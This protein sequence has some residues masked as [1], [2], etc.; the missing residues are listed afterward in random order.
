MN[1]KDNS[2]KQVL[3]I[4][5]ERSIRESIADYLEDIGCRPYQASDGASAIRMI[6]SSSFDAIVVDLTMPGIDGY[7]VVKYVASTKPEVPVIVLSG[8]G[9][10]DRAMESIRYGAWDYISKP[11]SRMEVLGMAL[12]RGFEKAGLLKENRMYKEHLEEEVEKK[13]AQILSLSNEMIRTQ[14]EIILTLGDVVE[15]RSHETAH[16]VDRVAEF[17]YL[18]ALRSGMDESSAS[19]LRIAAP[20]HDVGKIGI[21]DTILNKPGGLTSEEMEMMKNHTVIGNSIFKNSNLPAL[22]LAAEVALCHHERWDGLGYPGGIR[23][24][25]IPLGARITSIA[26]VFDAVTHERVYK[27]AWDIDTSFSYIAENGGS[28]FDPRLTGIFVSIRSEVMK[29]FH[30]FRD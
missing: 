18:L 13:T 4:D 25:A 7:D 21:P 19:E 29:I 9:I 27:K 11:L 26:D 17:A 1:G 15:T 24:D 12:G 3:V 20:M 16:H 2:G 5:D 28:Y 14:K 22:A 8:I 23:A 6:E 30:K 10:I